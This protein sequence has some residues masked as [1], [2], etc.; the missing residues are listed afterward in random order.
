MCLS[1]RFKKS[2]FTVVSKKLRHGSDTFFVK[3]QLQSSKS[4]AEFFLLLTF[5]SIGVNNL[6]AATALVRMKI[7]ITSS[8]SDTPQVSFACAIVFQLLN[9][10]VKI[11][12]LLFD[13]I[14]TNNLS[15]MKKRALLY[16]EL[17]STSFSHRLYLSTLFK[18]D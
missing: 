16:F 9:E 8:F 7:P 18:I 2:G 11:Y 13:R 5:Y 17:H 1:P 4:V 12:Y 15:S 10:V 3:C 14:K 6:A